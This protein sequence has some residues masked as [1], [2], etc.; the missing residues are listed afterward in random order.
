GQLRAT[1]TLFYPTLTSMFLEV[2]F[3]L[4]LAW[5]ANSRAAFVALL[6][7]GA[8]VIATFTRSG[9]IT[10]VMSLAVYGGIT[11]LRARRWSGEHARIVALAIVLVV[12]AA[13]SRS[14]QM[15]LARM[16]N[17]GSQEWYGA[18]YQV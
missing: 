10:M 1:A 6:L 17:E 8:G 13:M 15:L 4:G 3:A 11:F 16:S 5:I 12:L 2:A 14:P 18:T 7:A 9:L